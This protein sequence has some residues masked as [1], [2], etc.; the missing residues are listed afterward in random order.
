MTPKVIV[1][2]PEPRASAAL[3]VFEF[4]KALHESAVP[5]ALFCPENFEYAGQLHTAGIAL[6]PA[7]ARPVSPASLVA[8]LWRNA[9]WVAKTAAMQFKIT[10]PGDLVHF[11]FLIH[12]PLGFIFL[13]LVRSKRAGIVFT[14]HD[15]LPHKWRLPAS[16]R[17]LE[18][19]MLAWA[20][21]LCD[22]IIVHNQIGKGILIDE[23]Q[24]PA[25]RIA[26]VPHGPL[27]AAPES[28]AYPEADVL[29]LLLFGS[30]R[31]NKGVHLAI[32]AIQNLGG[33]VRLTIAG[34]VTAAHREYWKHCQELIRRDAQSIDVLE[35]YFEDDEL[36]PLLARHHA[37]LM[38]YLDF[39]SESGVASLALSSERPIIS[40]AAG[41]LAELLE[42]SGGGILIEAPSAEGIQTAIE[43]ASALGFAALKQKGVD[44]SAYL[45]AAR[46]WKTIGE[47][48]RQVYVTLHGPAIGTA[49]R[50]EIPFPGNHG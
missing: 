1:Q 33:K 42:Q 3:Y 23:F 13:L 10:Q 18:K 34:S 15:P 44:G 40:T 36:P 35:R 31:E 6:L 32:E 46:S 8:R 30:I 7:P 26:I 25:E 11:Q 21:R 24:Y 43:N 39:F 17:W 38:P 5:V 14:A 29:R 41:G 49:K 12:L 47:K 27:A 16:L 22:A 37:V 45:Q 9:V 4:V 20:Y 2:T 50:F 28:A 48:T 19:G